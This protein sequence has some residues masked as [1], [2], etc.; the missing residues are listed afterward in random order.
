MTITLELPPDME[1]EIPAWAAER[2]QA[3]SHYLLT[4][5][6]ADVYGEIEMSEAERQKETAPI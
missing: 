4:L 1:S 3:V 5:A 2:G 6:E